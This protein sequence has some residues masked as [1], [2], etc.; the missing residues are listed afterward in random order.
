MGATT[1]AGEVM[2]GRPMN[3]VAISCRTA[4]GQASA[5]LDGLLPVGQKKQMD[6]HIDGCQECSTRLQKMQDV[7]SSMRRMPVRVP[8]KSLNSRLRV[9]ASR[10]LARQK[11]RA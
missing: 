3:T 11:S 1:G 2:T 4:A 8:P 9:V 10:E 6:A 5:F 7:R